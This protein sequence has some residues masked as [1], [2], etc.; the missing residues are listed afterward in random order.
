MPGTGPRSASPRVVVAAVVSLT[1]LLFAALGAAQAG[2]LRVGVLKFGTVNWTLDV[3]KAHELDAEEGVTL[4]IVP[5]AGKNATS[6]ALQARDVDMIVTDWFWV[7]R[8]RAEGTPFTFVPYS[9]AQGAVMVPPDAGIET[10][11]DLAGKRIGV[12]GGPIDKSWLLLQALGAKRHGVELASDAEPVFGAPPLLNEQILAGRIDAVINF[13]HYAARLEAAGLTRL[14][15]VQDIMAEL[16]IAEVIPMIGYTFDEGWAAKN[17]ADLAAFL[18]AEQ[19]AKALLAESD[20]EWERLRPLMK[21]KDDASFIA[22]RDAYRAG[23]P[24]SWGEAEQNSAARLYALLA[25]I[26]GAKLV[27]KAMTLQDGTFWSGGE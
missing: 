2:E 1:T 11:G 17:T 5:F 3:I 15:G 12:A 7:S 8:E 20:A 4:E 18:R 25:E 6:V 14:A 13:W 23:I 24:K 21:A 16:G 9:T 22:L 19:A 10:V 26:G 27:G